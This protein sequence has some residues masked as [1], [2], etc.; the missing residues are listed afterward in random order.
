MAR[1][2]QRRADE[3][4]LEFRVGAPRAGI[5]REIRTMR[6]LIA[7]AAAAKVAPGDTILI[8]AGEVSL[9]L[10]E[11]LKRARD[12]TVVTNSLEVMQLLAEVPGLKVIV[13]SGEYQA[14]HACLVGPS[15]GALF[16]TLKVDKA[17]LA[18]DGVS[19]RFGASAA[20]ER[21]AL[22]ARRFANAS[23][24][25]FVLADHS[26]VGNDRIAPIDTVDEVITDSG[27]LPADRLA[28][29][30]AGTRV[31]LAD[32]PV[33]EDET[34]LDRRPGDRVLRASRAAL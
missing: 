29:A 24:Q 11:E 28:L 15:L 13:T 10:A 8:N 26:L 33:S 6:E 18:V 20:D 1:A 30:S 5:A 31:S 27:S 21:L 19:A 32:E 16:E 9:L 3:V 17:F 12:L 4:G 22:A 2:M 7:R 34:W 25:V 23:R 14:K